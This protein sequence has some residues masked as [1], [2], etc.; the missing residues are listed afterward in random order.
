ML[1]TSLSALNSALEGYA[2]RSIKKIEKRKWNTI[3]VEE[4]S[5]INSF[6]DNYNDLIGKYKTPC[7]LLKMKII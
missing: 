7:L 3:P 5:Q 2:L 1:N 4:R 6:F